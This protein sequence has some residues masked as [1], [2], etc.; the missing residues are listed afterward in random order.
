MR[1]LN[2]HDIVG[3]SHFVSLLGR[4]AVWERCLWKAKKKL[5]SIRRLYEQR[6]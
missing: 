6:K 5:C 1:R 3:A 2:G 4:Y